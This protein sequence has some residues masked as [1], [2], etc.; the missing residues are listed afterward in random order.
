MAPECAVCYACM[1]ETKLREHL[2]YHIEDGVLTAR[3]ARRAL[4][5]LAGGR[6]A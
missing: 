4:R 1:S 3:N 5:L 6:G 2:E